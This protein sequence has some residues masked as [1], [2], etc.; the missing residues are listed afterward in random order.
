MTATL[1]ASD[2]A[3]VAWDVQDHVS[4]DINGKCS[5]DP[6]CNE[7]GETSCGCHCS[8][9][10]CVYDITSGAERWYQHDGCYSVADSGANPCDNM[11]WDTIHD[12]DADNPP[13]GYSNPIEFNQ[14]LGTWDQNI[15]TR[16]G[17]D[18]YCFVFEYYRLT[19]E[20]Q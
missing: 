7:E 12:G 14:Y 6:F 15:C 13:L 3:A 5:T 20:C 2:G 16:Y 10:G 19:W 18:W 1:R 17:Y 9:Y 8:G 4:S 11:T